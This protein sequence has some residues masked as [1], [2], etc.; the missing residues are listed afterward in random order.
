MEKHKDL[1]KKYKIKLYKLF[2]IVVE[3]VVAGTLIYTDEHKTF[4]VL[5]GLDLITGQHVTK[6]N[7]VNLEN[8]CNT[9][10]FKNFLK[11]KIKKT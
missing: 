3:H 7:F 8:S 10:N 5:P 11:H 1:F 4:T 9:Q 6:K 2:F